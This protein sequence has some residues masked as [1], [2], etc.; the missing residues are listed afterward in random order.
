MT[1]SYNK[2]Y[3][4]KAQNTL[5]SMLDYA[6]SDLGYSLKEFYDLF[7]ASNIS[8]IF[9]SGDCS[10]IAGKSGS[11]LALEII[12]E[13]NVKDVNTLPQPIFNPEHTSVYWTGWALSFYQWYRGLSFQEINQKIGIDDIHSLYYPYHEMDI[14]QFVNKMNE[15]L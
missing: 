8:T 7:L 9:A 5:S 4:E 2:L 1:S 15:L 3:L 11:E 14:M 13:L 12:S 10:V 6:V